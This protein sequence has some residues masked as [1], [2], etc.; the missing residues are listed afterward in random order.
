MTQIDTGTDIDIVWQN[1]AAKVRIPLAGD[2]TQEWCQRYQ[3]RARRESFPARAEKHP[4]RGWVIVDLP[5]GTGPPDIVAAL[6]AAR[7]LITA[8]DDAGEAPDVQQTETVV[9]TWWADQRG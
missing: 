8:T 3:A 5:D 4:G 7:D 6:D 2:V 9:R 1:G